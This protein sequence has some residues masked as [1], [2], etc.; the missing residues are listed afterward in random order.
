[1]C[2]LDTLSIGLR[3]CSQRSA[4]FP[5]PILVRMFWA[6]DIQVTKLQTPFCALGHLQV[7]TCSAGKGFS[8]VHARVFVAEKSCTNV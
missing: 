1:M 6:L 7:F 4:K 2:V 8:A 3:G 5:K